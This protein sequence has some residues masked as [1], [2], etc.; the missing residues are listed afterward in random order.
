MEFLK[1]R[2]YAVVHSVILRAMLQMCTT[3]L[4]MVFCIFLSLTLE[5]K[6]CKLPRL[7]EIQHIKMWFY[8]FLWI[9]EKPE[10]KMVFILL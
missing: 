3:L 10:V 2:K 6:I 4:E 8:E 1:D 7:R 9:C 5:S